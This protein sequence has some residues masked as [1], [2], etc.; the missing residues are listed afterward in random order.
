[1]R[2]TQNL[3]RCLKIRNA[4]KLRSHRHFVNVVYCD[5]INTSSLG[6]YFDKFSLHL[7]LLS[8][9]KDYL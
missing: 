3:D 9:I 8:F 4:G 6:I 2:M 1:M 5:H 7:L